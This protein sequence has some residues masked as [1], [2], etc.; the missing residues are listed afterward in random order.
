[1]NMYNPRINLMIAGAIFAFLL[2]GPCD[3]LPQL[4]GF[5]TNARPPSAPPLQRQEGSGTA[6]PAVVSEPSSSS[7]PTANPAYTQVEEFYRIATNGPALNGI[8]KPTVFTTT[9]YWLVTDIVD[10]HWNQ[11]KGTAAPGTISLKAG[12]GTLYGPW[13]ASGTPG[14]GGVVNAYWL[15]HPNIVL[16]PETYTVID[17]DESTW[18]QTGGAGMSWGEGI[19]QG[20]P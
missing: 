16:P 20:N 17:S 7:A 19:R 5:D 10:Y 8:T 11:A 2:A 6:T 3:R 14:S 1:M 4:I 18:A 15:V 13:Q 9:D 12:D